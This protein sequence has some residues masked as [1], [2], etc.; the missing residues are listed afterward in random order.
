MRYSDAV[1]YLESLINYEKLSAYD[2][3]GSLK[4]ERIIR[5]LEL[6]GEPH[7]DVP[8][9][10]IAGTK[11]KGSTAAMTAS[12]LQEAGLR[13]GLYTSPHL[14][15]FRERIRLNGEFIEKDAVCSLLEK[16]RPA[17]EEL[18]SKF[19]QAPSFFEVY[20]ALAFMY[21]A[22]RHISPGEPL[23]KRADI[24]VLETGLGGRLDATNVVRPLVCGITQ[25]SYDHTDK[26]GSTLREIAGEKCGI[27]KDNSVCVSACQEK[28]ALEVI[29]EA[30]RQRNT[31]LY[32]VGRDICYMQK[33]CSEQ[34]QTFKVS[35]IFDTYESLEIS[36]LGEHQLV[37]AATA[38][39][40]VEALKL[41]GID[42]SPIAVRDGLKNA[43]WPGRLERVM[44]D[45]AVIL[46]GAQNRASA[47]ALA[48]AIKNIF[49]YERLFLVLGIS[50]D[51]DIKGIC[52]ELNPIADLVIFTKASLPRAAE[53]EALKPY[54]NNKKSFLADDV[55]DAVSLAMRSAG[56]GDLILVT[57]SLF[58][59]GEAREI[60]LKTQQY[61]RV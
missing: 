3:R 59:V 6:L 55:K 1:K 41:G 2:Y 7:K 12:V 33:E 15:D 58:V 32:L 28:E 29:E 38:I 48:K 50:K 26:L 34:G 52:D 43:K 49:K 39:G 44:A 35:G 25:I 17:V 21:F 61:Q 10:H 22:G 20:T 27:I 54:F 11:G 18:N 24:M 23:A 36:L 45:P 42:I 16:I 13:T 51:K 4:L 46:D 53:P 30:C 8:A 56:P 31:R 47:Q 60:F 57:G 40:I 5:L 9:V 14:S 19:H 37:N